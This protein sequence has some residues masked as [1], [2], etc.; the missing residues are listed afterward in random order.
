MFV[1]PAEVPEADN[2]LATRQCKLNGNNDRMAACAP[3]RQSLGGRDQR[4]EKVKFLSC[5]CDPTCSSSVVS[6]K[7]FQLSGFRGLE[8]SPGQCTSAEW[9]ITSVKRGRHVYSPP[10]PREQSHLLSDPVVFETKPAF[11][12]LAVSHGGHC[13][14]IPRNFGELSHRHSDGI[15][16]KSIRRDH[17]RLSISLLLKRGRSSPSEH[18]SSPPPPPAVDHTEADEH[19]EHDDHRRVGWGGL[20]PRLAK[21]RGRRGRRLDWGRRRRAHNRRA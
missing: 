19:N 10:S 9:Q 6:A 7:W 16:G 15:L 13:V 11:G 5:T 3:V 1:R 8:V 12:L 21:G 2:R 14:G 17:L 4:I 20:S 18:A